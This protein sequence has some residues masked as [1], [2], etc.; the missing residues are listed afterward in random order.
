[1]R[2][3]HTLSEA[4]PI[5]NSEPR[6]AKSRRPASGRSSGSGSQ[7]PARIS[8]STPSG[9]DWM[10]G[11]QAQLAGPHDE[12]GGIRHPATFRTYPSHRA[13]QDHPPH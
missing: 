4:A 2:R 1:M 6:A 12:R 7:K 8:I 10:T 11:D 9:Y 3:H 13:K 5:A